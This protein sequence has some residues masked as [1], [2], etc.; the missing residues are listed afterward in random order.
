MYV[1]GPFTCYITPWGIYDSARISVTKVFGPMLLTL[2][3]GGIVQ[4][5]EKALYNTQI[6]KGSGR[7]LVV[8][9]LD[10]GL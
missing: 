2:Q 4:F 5:S 3:V 7:G 8:R 10:S 1:W 6:W 9:V